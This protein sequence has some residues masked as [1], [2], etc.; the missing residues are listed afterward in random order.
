[1]A[2]AS[3]KR[4]AAPARDETQGAVTLPLLP[5]EN[6]RFSKVT[7]SSKS[8]PAAPT[9]CL[10]EAPRSINNSLGSTWEE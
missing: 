6:K 3:C 4:I 2:A 1:M 5:R 9:S 7:G 10:D 8:M